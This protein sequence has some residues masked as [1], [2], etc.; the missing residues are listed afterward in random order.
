[1]ERITNK[2]RLGEWV[3][4]TSSLQGSSGLFLAVVLTHLKQ[5]LGQIV[6]SC[7]PVCPLGEGGER[8]PWHPDKV[9]EVF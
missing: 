4:R 8:C 9:H 2:E 7:M 5:T 1:M 3:V 6:D